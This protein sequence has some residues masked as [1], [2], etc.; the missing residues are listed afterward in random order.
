M[1]D[2]PGLQHHTSFIGKDLLLPLAALYRFAEILIH[3]K[4]FIAD[5]KP[6]PTGDIS[7]ELF[8]HNYINIT[9]GTDFY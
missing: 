7:S 3:T 9:L 6:S 8:Y 4:K 5:R 2:C 1:T